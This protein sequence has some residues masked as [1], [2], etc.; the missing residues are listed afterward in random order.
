MPKKPIKFLFVGRTATGK[1]SI[2]EAVSNKMGLRVVKS[3]T[4]RPPRES[5]LFGRS[6]HYFVSD[7]EFD[8]IG[9][10]Y[11][12]SAETI[13]NGYRYATTFEEINNSDIYVIDPNGV[14][15]LFNSCRTWFDFVVIYFRIPYTMAEK[16]YIKRG[17]TKQKFKE[18]YDKESEQFEA[19]EK[20]QR[21]SY[22]LLNDRPFDESVYMVCQWIKNELEH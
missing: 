4:T 22:H 13:I 15:A 2:A 5:E 1:S 17:G 20:Q 18:R 8:E 21:F 16:R 6:D 14:D 7:E 12:F 10:V 3:Y 9:S 11:G 19:F